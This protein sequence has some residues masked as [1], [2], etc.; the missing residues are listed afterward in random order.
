[1]TWTMCFCILAAVHT[2]GI[3]SANDKSGTLLHFF[4]AVIY[5]L[6]AIVALGRS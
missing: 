2:V 3:T 4:I 1:M 5:S 6:F